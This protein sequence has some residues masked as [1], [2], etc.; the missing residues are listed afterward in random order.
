MDEETAYRARPVFVE[1][2]KQITPDE[3]RIL[4]TIVNS[5][6]S[7]NVFSLSA[8]N[9]LN[10]EPFGLLSDLWPVG[11][12]AECK[13]LDL[14]PSY[15]DNLA[16]LGI[17]SSISVSKACA[18]FAPKYFNTAIP[19]NESEADRLTVDTDV[20]AMARFHALQYEISRSYGGSKLL[21][22]VL[23][24]EMSPQVHEE[25]QFTFSKYPS[26]S[27]I[28]H[29]TDSFPEIIER[30]KSVWKGEENNEVFD[31]QIPPLCDLCVSSAHLTNF[32]KQ[33]C[34]VCV[35]PQGEESG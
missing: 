7:T 20:L 21:T 15:M 5:H 27:Q 13:Y 6:G 11:Q 23:H 29:L 10:V 30:I 24:F 33:F 1:V 35:L 17:L 25:A 3:A 16:R 34:E 9:P 26:I 4:K 31:G 22:R 18:T 32:G 2:L 28:Q 14:V 12:V 8:Y 19:L